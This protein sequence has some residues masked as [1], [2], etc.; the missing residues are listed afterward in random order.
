MTIEYV[1]NTNYSKITNLICPVKNVVCP[2]RG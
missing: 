1:G 2:V